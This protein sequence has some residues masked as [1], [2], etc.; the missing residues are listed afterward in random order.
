MFLSLFVVADEIEEEEDDEPP[1]KYN[2]LIMPGTK[3]VFKMSDVLFALRRIVLN[4]NISR[5]VRP[6][7]LHLRYHPGINVAIFHQTHYLKPMF[8]RFIVICKIDFLKTLH[9]L[10]YFRGSRFF[11]CNR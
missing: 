10:C 8:A 6:G 1:L 3:I 4:L 7:S 2:K 5:R 11:G 9:I